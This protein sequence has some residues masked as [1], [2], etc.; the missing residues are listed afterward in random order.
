MELDQE[1]ADIG[2]IDEFPQFVEDRI[3]TADEDGAH[4]VDVLPV[5]GVAEHLGADDGIFQIELPRGGRQAAR[6]HGQAAA[7][8]ALVALEAIARE[9]EHGLA[10]FLPRDLVGLAHIDAEQKAHLAGMEILA[11]LLHHLAK[12][13]GRALGARELAAGGEEVAEVAPRHLIHGLDAVGAG[14][15]DGG[16]GRLQ[17]LRPWVHIAHGI[18]LALEACR[19]RLGP[20]LHDEIHSLPEALA[21]QRHGIGIAVGLMPAARREA[22]HQPP[23]R[24]AIEHGVFLRHAQ[25]TEGQRQQIAQHH[26]LAFLG[27]LRERGG[28][29]IGRGHDAVDVL[30]M[31]VEHHAI[32]AQSVGGGHFVQIFL[33]EAHGLLAVEEGVGNRDPAALVIPIKILVEIGPGHEVPRKDADLA[34]VRHDGSSRGRMGLR[35]AFVVIVGRDLPVSSIDRALTLR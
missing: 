6:R 24:H 29:Q 3:G 19:S 28:Q 9:I 22:R 5:L 16:M 31:L 25:R 33:I 17:G 21:R 35:H 14:D 32:E 13:Q 10:A 26:Q 7:L 23:V 30:V 20:G 15:P 18:V 4:L 8:A 2:F 34:R 27:G 12:A 11:D 1:I